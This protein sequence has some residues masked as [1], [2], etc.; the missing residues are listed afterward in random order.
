[1]ASYNVVFAIDVDYRSEHHNFSKDKYQNCLKQWILRF[2]LTLGSKYGFEKVRWGY[3]FFHS[4]TVKHGSL[5]TRGT[6]FK[7]LHEKVFSD[8]EEELLA[9][10][11]VSERTPGEQCKVQHSQ[12]SCVQNT[13]K[14]ILLDFQWD[15]P[16]IT[17]PTKLT[18]R[19]RRSSRNTKNISL[20]DD[21]LSCLGKN[22]LFVVS[23]CPYSKRDLEAFLLL[24]S[25]DSESH[26]DLLELVLPKRLIDMIIQRNIVLHWADSGSLKVNNRVGDCMGLRAIMEVL[27]L[28]AGKVVPMLTPCLALNHT[29]LTLSTV[30]EEAIC[31]FPSGSITGY[32]LS[33]K[34]THQRAFPALEGTLCWGADEGTH[35]CSVSLE[36]VSCGQKL[37]SAP[38]EV[39][40]TSVLHGLDSCSFSQLASESWVLLCP[41]KPEQE[42]TL[43]QCLLKELSTQAS[44]MLAEVYEGG[45][46][47][48]AVLSVL[49]PHTVLL[50]ILQPLVTQ[51]EEVVDMSL[52]SSQTTQ[53]PVDLPNVVSSVL[54]AMYD[55]MKDDESSEQTNQP[56]IPD[57]ANQ[58]LQQ[59]PNLKTD[60]TEGWFPL[61]DQSGISC[62]LMESMRLLHAAPE[63]EI[64]REF[65]T[66]LELTHS[67]AE[68]YQNNTAGP[69]TGPKGKKRGAQHT[70]MR[71]KMKTMSRSLQMLNFARF[72]VKAQKSQAETD[73]CST[74]RGATRR[75][76]RGAG[77]RTT[78]GAMYFKSEEEL[79][80]HLKLSYQQAV[81][82]KSA[83][84]LTQVQGLLSLVMTFMR[85]N[86]GAE[87]S[88]S[89]LIKMNLLK[90]AQ[91][92]RQIYGSAPDS[93]NKIRDCQLQ[94]V[95]RLELCRQSIS[96][97]DPDHME[98]MVEEMAGMLR[99]I[100]L[101]NDPVYLSKFMKEEVLPLYLNGIPKVLADIYYSLGSQLPEE[102]AAVLPP[103]FL[104]DDS[105]AKESVSVSPSPLSTI[106]ST[107]SNAGDRLE[108]LRNR[109]AKKR[110]TSMLTRHKSLTEAPQALRQIEMPR[111]SS[112]QAK[113]TRC[114]PSERFSVGSQ[115]PQKRAV[116]EVTKV[117]RNLFNQET[118][119]P[120][121]KMKMPRSQSVSAVEGLKKRKRS[122]MEDDRHS[123]LTKKVS[124]TPLHKQVSNRLL[125]RQKSGRRSD[126]T[127]MFVVE[128]S[129]VKPVASLRRSPRIKSLARRHSSVF[130]SSSQ[131]RSRNLDRALSLSQLTALEG[132]GAINV[133]TVKSPMRLLF[134]AAQSPGCPSTSARE[135]RNTKEVQLGSTYSGFE[136]HDKTPRKPLYKQ[137][138][139]EIGNR[140]PQTPKT[141]PSSRAKGS[142]LP[143]SPG[144]AVGENGMVLRGSPFRSPAAMSLVWEMPKKSPVKGILRT[145][146]KNFMEYG[147]ISGTCLRSPSMRTPRK[148]VTWSPSQQ[149]CLPEKTFKVPESPQS[150]TRCSPRLMTPSKFCT[151]QVD[152]FKTPEKLSQRKFR[153]SP[154][155]AQRGS[156]ISGN[157]EPKLIQ[158]S[159]NM[160]RTLS[161]PEKVDP[162]SPA[163]LAIDHPSPTTPEIT[164]KKSP[165]PSH[166]MCTHSERTPPKPSPSPPH[167]NESLPMYDKLLKPILRSDTSD[168]RIFD[169]TNCPSTSSNCTK[170][171][172]ALVRA[173]RIT[174]AIERQ[175]ESTHEMTGGGTSSSDTQQ[176][177]SSQFSGTTT[178]ESIDIA[179]ASVVKTELSGGVKMNIAFSRKSSRP[180]GFEFTGAQTLS[181]EN[182]Q[183]MCSYGFR[184]TPD[185]Q[186]RKAAARLGYSGLPVFSTPQDSGRPAHR[187]KTDEPNPLTYQV[188]LEMQASG[189][190][191]LKFKRT[192]S[193]N[194]DE[195]PDYVA[196][197]L[198]PIMNTKS[199]RVDSPLAHCSKHR[200]PCCLSPSLCT[201]GTPRKG[202]VQTHICQ[203]ITP[204]RLP[205]NSPSP[206]GPGEH[207]PW[208]PSPQKRGWTTPENFRSWP[209]KKRARTGMLG[210]KEKGIKAECDVL[211]NPELDGV[212][213]LQGEEEIKESKD[214]PAFK[215]A[216]GTR[217]R[218]ST[219]ED[220]DLSESVV[221]LGS[222]GSVVTPPNCKMKKPV[223]V[224]GILALT[225]SPLLYRG[226]KGSAKTDTTQTDES[227]GNLELCG[228]K[229]V[230]ML[231]VSPFSQ[232]RRHQ[233]SSRNYSRKRLLDS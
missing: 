197:N 55:I 23:E 201:Y 79:L 30:N 73:S 231:D 74:A 102:L 177:D 58:E 212:F 85:S 208:T 100:S 199:S 76:T 111:R 26:T 77:E 126:E 214:V 180:E 28:V 117:R 52:V 110:R 141:P 162:Q 49:S 165:G 170:F 157:K 174:K 221:Q 223:S 132:K 107:G 80:S 2:L 159:D 54:N 192:N 178:E 51:S 61:S 196:K 63:E 41:D 20:A 215:H 155:T 166:R 116:Q 131:S 39:M 82:D 190:P 142:F 71:Q 64:Q 83:P 37:L 10:F 103:D 8:F 151:V 3:T 216:L 140:T 42:R 186:Q 187:K 5:I 148:S 176:L 68:F 200:E 21:E 46:I 67:L 98:Q 91:S 87:A 122:Q 12:A 56:Q 72:S 233:R 27:Q 129:P 163:T 210:T 130:Y 189:L 93:D 108:E 204:T 66:E 217:S 99:I 207:V 136:N 144:Y 194:L 158:R 175:N 228:N 183:A 149:K 9:K 121:K 191:K 211:E 15:R 139:S 124:E 133:N 219:Q 209:R 119:S 40:L 6:D 112:R 36:P 156:E 65:S 152:V 203:S 227:T 81:E 34:K 114:V 16:D 125:H 94:V 146:V 43:F 167:Y 182:T 101:T 202:G 59:W 19:H 185:R 138:G 1:M 60:F 29:N 113:P 17:S 161:L 193:F 137:S 184:Q 104:S 62:H 75:S 168:S 45:S 70:P 220:M 169:S 105:I 86:T 154:E 13:L 173:S 206:L 226:E 188:E 145:P 88:F 84:L 143:K 89:D 22:V 198:T 230:F 57:W 31:T 213:R 153:L 7:E 14:E 128:E 118:M 38:V 179:E 18:V 33:S 225:Q 47:H 95:L 222:V 11:T 181:A 24:R 48:S 106:Q 44:N 109:S 32:I 25:G 53:D 172:Q 115:P 120:S 150:S 218:F 69:S 229:G 171:S 134:G 92:V 35:A 90:S 205:A 224:S 147:T 97:Q 195:Q 127:D 96:D 78:A 4:K 232:P 50:T 160:N 135:T 164:P 123:L